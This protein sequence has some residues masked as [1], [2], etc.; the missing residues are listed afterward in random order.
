MGDGYELKCKRC[1]YKRPVYFGIG[2]SYP[3]VCERIL[4]AM[5]NGDLGKRFMEY[6]QSTPHAAVHQEREIFVCDHCGEWR[7]DETIDLCTPIGE[8]KKREGR[9]SVAVDSSKDIP[10]VM[11]FDIGREYKII[12]SKQ[13]RCGK[14]HHAMRPIKKNEKLKCPECGEALKKGNEI[15]W[16]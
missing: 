12:H 6:A 3:R 15:N 14:C 9:F 1:G 8:G 16:D 10:Y 11:T 4:E 7:A 13:H 5:K 2:F